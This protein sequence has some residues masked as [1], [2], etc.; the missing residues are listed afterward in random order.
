MNHKVLAHSICALLICLVH[1]ISRFN[2]FKFARGDYG[3]NFRQCILLTHGFIA[4]TLQ[5]PLDALT[6]INSISITDGI[7]IYDSNKWPISLNQLIKSTG[8]NFRETGQLIDRNCSMLIVSAFCQCNLAR[9]KSRNVE[10]Q[11]QINFYS[12][13][14]DSYLRYSLR[15]VGMLCP[16]AIP[17]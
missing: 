17:A 7:I 3:C 5:W 15:N 9:S 16:S 13:N 4:S 14:N 8:D 1:Q 11:S 2:L 12:K 6:A 10:Y